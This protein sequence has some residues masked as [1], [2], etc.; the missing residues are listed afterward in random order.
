MKKLF[1]VLAGL[2]GV[3]VEKKPLQTQELFL[4]LGLIGLPPE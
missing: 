1:E 2:T 3:G 4:P